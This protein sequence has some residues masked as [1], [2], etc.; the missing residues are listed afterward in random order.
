LSTKL[1]A[2]VGVMQVQFPVV[3]S[4]LLIGHIVII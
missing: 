2:I 3:S 1:N 4:R